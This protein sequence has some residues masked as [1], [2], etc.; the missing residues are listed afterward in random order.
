MK[1][2][3]GE[4]NYFEFNWLRNWKPVQFEQNKRDVV[5]FARAC[6]KEAEK[7]HMQKLVN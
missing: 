2:F 7:W 1:S 4:Q 5:E 6:N 3:I